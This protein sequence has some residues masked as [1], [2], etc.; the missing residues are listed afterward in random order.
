MRADICEPT[1]IATLAAFQQALQSLGA[2]KEDVLD[3]SLGVRLVKF[4]IGQETLLVF[5]DNW[6]VDI[7]GSEPLVVEVSNAVAEAKRRLDK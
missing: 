2:E 4:R 6:S 3:S 7:E 5:N 1:D